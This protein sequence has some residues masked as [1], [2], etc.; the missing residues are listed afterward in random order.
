VSESEPSLTRR[1]HDVLA[2]L[3]AAAPKSLRL[4]GPDCTAA[5]A[6]VKLGLAKVTSYPNS[7]PGAWFAAN[8]GA[9][10]ERGKS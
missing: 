2:R 6:L 5:S 1:Q 9:M 4:T 10:A 7:G 8:E 3:K